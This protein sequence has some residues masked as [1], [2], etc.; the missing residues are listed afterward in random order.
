MH[1]QPSKKSRNDLIRLFLATFTFI[2]VYIALIGLSLALIALLIALLLYTIGEKIPF[3]AVFIVAP[4]G[5]A[6]FIVMA[7]FRIPLRLPKVDDTEERI[8]LQR[9]DAPKLFEIISELATEIGAPMPTQVYA[10]R[11]VNA[12]LQVAPPSFKNLFKPSQQL[13]L[14]FGAI[15]VLNQSELKALIAHELGHAIQKTNSLGYFVFKFNQLMQKVLYDNTYENQILE[16]AGERDKTTLELI[17]WFAAY[18]N[19]WIQ[20]FLRFLFSRITINFYGVS[21]E[22]EFHADAIA[23]HVAGP[24]PM[25]TALLQL[26]FADQAIN[27]LLQFYGN[28][29][30]QG[31]QS[32]NIFEDFRRLLTHLASEN[33]IAMDQ[34]RPI[35]TPQDKGLFISSKLV[36]V[37]QWASHPSMKERLE[38]LAMHTQP[39]QEVA[40]NAAIHLFLASEQLELTMTKQFFFSTD[41]KQPISYLSHDAFIEEY[42]Q[43]SKPYQFPKCFNRYYD[44]HNPT[45]LLSSTKMDEI[46]KGIA[47]TNLFDNETIAHVKETQAL[48]FDIHNMQQLIQQKGAISFEY[49]GRKYNRKYAAKQMVAALEKELKSREEALAEHDQKIFQFF[50]ALARSLNSEKQ[51]KSDYESLIA[52]DKKLHEL[53]EFQEQVSSFLVFISEVTPFHIIKENL[54]KF[55]PLEQK[56]KEEMELLVKDKACAD[57][58]PPEVEEKIQDFI[59]EQLHY[60]GVSIYIDENLEKLYTAI[61]YLPILANQKYFVLKK[62]LLDHMAML[63]TKKT[64]LIDKYY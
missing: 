38:R 36:A 15:T 33:Q 42:I 6:I 9:E 63:L 62:D 52:F 28:R 10:E 8:P 64:T 12:G 2:G 60:F 51:L 48:Q 31:I 58:L 39:N 43:S 26:H 54:R 45:I 49:D 23:A 29:Y 22:M 47:F 46:P 14:G 21:R 18:T 25:A 7:L 37:D 40:T 50:M 57:A 17:E 56:L 5:I 3:L 11:S 13:I 32:Q 61:N 44:Y 4:I 53:Y 24:N 41:A 55:K 1:I 27:E 20:Q 35:F 59:R 16:S 19:R 30:E 34:G